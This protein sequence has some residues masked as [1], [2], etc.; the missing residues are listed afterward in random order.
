M[1]TGKTLARRGAL[2][3]NFWIA[4]SNGWEGIY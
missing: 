4:F 1:L 2:S 3:A